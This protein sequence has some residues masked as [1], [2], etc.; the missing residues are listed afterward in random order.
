MSDGMSASPQNAAGQL[1]ERELKRLLGHA[2]R[3]GA[4]KRRR[5]FRDGGG[6]RYQEWTGKPPTTP[7]SRKQAFWSPAEDALLGTMTDRKLARKLGR[8]VKAVKGRRQHKRICF[9]LKPWRPEDEKVLG[10]RPDRQIATLL[11][12]T[13]MNVAQRRRML[14]IPCF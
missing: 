10:T 1:S 5:P 9:L 2:Y 12:R 13:L 4:S 11:G 6:D 7:G 14:G 8:S 3:P